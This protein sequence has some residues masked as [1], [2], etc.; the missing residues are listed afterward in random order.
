MSAATVFDAPAE[1]SRAIVL[2]NR[3][4]HAQDYTFKRLSGASE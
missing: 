4:T 3:N 1:R 2:V